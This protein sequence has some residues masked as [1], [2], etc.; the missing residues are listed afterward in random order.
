MGYA[1][2]LREPVD[3]SYGTVH[4]A[5]KF[6]LDNWNQSGENEGW[7]KGMQ[8]RRFSFLKEVSV[9]NNWAV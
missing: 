5:S 1:A 4:K 2:P 9:G 8:G 3:A 7:D 6:I